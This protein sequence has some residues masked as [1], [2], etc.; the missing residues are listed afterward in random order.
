[1]ISIRREDYTHHDPRW[2]GGDKEDGSDAFQ[3]Y[4]NGGA[5]LNWSYFTVKAFEK[6][7]LHE[8]LQQITD[9]ILA[10]INTGDFQGS[11]EKGGMTKD[12]KSWHGECW[13]MRVF[14][15]TVIWYY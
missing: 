9:G 5:S 11:C 8:P 7:G 4:E 1:L 14:Y 15:A 13:D 2:G 6:A 12:W 10:A 3:R